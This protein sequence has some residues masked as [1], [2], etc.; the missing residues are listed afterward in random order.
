M[1]EDHIR[2]DILTQEALRGVV[3]KVLMEVVQTGLPGEHHF[4]ISF[5]TRFPGVR[6]SPRML[7][8][9]PEEM[10]IVLQHQFW[11]LKVSENG[12]E[13]GL[14][15][16]DIPERLIVPYAAIKGFFDPCVQFGL[17]FD[18]E[19]EG[20]EP[21]EDE[22]ADEDDAP[23]GRVHALKNS[24]PAGLPKPEKGNDDASGDVESENAE[25]SDEE[26]GADVVSLDAFRKKP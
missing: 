11:D 24:K 4:F 15:F 26:S 20:V 5:D 9:Y 8:Q 23:S 2:Y 13:V 7:E 19:R 21:V 25:A 18:V 22:S 6:L 17:E 3:R 10:T 1:S 14:S 12:F 16:S